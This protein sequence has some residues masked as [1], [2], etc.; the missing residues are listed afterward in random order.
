[1]KES[2]TFEW[3]GHLDS[4]PNDY[5]CQKGNQGLKSYGLPKTSQ[6]YGD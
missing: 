5:L 1:M 2:T 4:F 6:L 3:N